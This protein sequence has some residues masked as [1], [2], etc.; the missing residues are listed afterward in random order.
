M[1]TE[2]ERTAGKHEGPNTSEIGCR[3]LYRLSVIVGGMYAL[4]YLVGISNSNRK[5]L[6]RPTSCALHI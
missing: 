1:I 5:K 3:G 2:Y 4:N 6:A